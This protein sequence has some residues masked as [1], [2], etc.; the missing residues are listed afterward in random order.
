[1]NTP[2][3]RREFLRRTSAVTGAALLGT[4][5]PPTATFAATPA[6]A[7]P[8]GLGFSLY[9]MKSLPVAD[10]LKACASIGYDNV[11]FALMPGYPTD[12]KLLSA[13]D[14]KQIATTL[15]DLGLRLSALMEN[16]SPLAAD[17]DHKK[18]LER[19][20][21]AA[22]LGHDL[23][24]NAPPVIETV[25]GGQPAQ[26]D[27][28]R[29][30]MA[31]RLRAWGDVAAAHKTIIAVK[32]HVGG[33]LHTPEGALWLVREVNHPAI[34]LTY[35]F[36]HY[37]LRGYS[38]APT[39]KDL[40]PHAAFIHVKDSEGTAAKFKFLLPGEGR[41]DYANYAALV[42]AAGYRGPVAVEVSGLI[43]NQKG[44]DPI[45]AAKKSY[46]ALAPHV[47]RKKE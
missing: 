27:A 2:L 47:Q 11:E 37:E 38:L 1:M 23:S 36:S 29:A 15:A 25:L 9:G 31:E 40:A 12:P 42:Q 35:D 33:A 21:V 41:I 14:R 32:P 10:A 17:A 24:P 18:N 46:A 6:P 5:S 26:W 39:W 34:K 45:A 19:L 20:A 28:V 3:P 8:F 7:R 16:I 43:F 22:V 30:Q 4:L 13:A 44:Y